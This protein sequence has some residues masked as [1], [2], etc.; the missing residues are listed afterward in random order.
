MFADGSALIR[1]EVDHHIIYPPPPG[2]QYEVTKEDDDSV[3]GSQDICTTDTRKSAG[4]YIDQ[5]IRYID[6]PGDYVYHI[7]QRTQDVPPKDKTLVEHIDGAVEFNENI[8]DSFFYEQEESS[9]E[10]NEEE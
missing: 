8:H 4:D 7:W 5:L 2:N 6:G 9:E 1:D 3:D 10:D